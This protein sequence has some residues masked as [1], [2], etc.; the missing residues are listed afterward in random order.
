MCNK[1]FINNF[2]LFVII[3]ERILP[4]EV[5]VIWMSSVTFTITGLLLYLYMLCQAQGQR[6]CVKG[7]TKMMSIQYM[8]L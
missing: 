4:F 8:G 1:H 6:Q 2:L 5:S 7:G 3:I